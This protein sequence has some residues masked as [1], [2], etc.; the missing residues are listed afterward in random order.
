M[1]KRIAFILLSSILALS[2]SLSAC[3]PK[4]HAHDLQ[5]HAAKAATCFEDGSKEYFECPDCGKLFKDAEGKTELSRD[6]LKIDAT[7]HR[8][9]DEWSFDSEAHWHAA[10]CGHNEEIKDRQLHNFVDDRCTV[11][12]ELNA[13]GGSVT[14]SAVGDF[15]ILNEEER[16]SERLKAIIESANTFAAKLSEALLKDCELTENVTVSPISVYMALA[17]TAEASGGETR[18][19]I[20]SVLGVT[21]EQLH[22][23]FELLYRAL[24][25]TSND[26][27]GKLL[28][29]LDLS[30][31]I[32]V[33]KAL[34]VNQS[35]LKTLA[36]KY[37]CGAH[38]A[39]FYNKN[40]LANRAIQEFV[41][42]K[43]RGL[44]D[45]NFNLSTDTVFAIINTLYLKDVWNGFGE[46]LSLTEKPYSFNEKEIQLLKGNYREGRAYEADTFTHFYTQTYSG[47]KLKFL[48][49]KEGYS[50][51]EIFT[52][53]NIAKVNA[54]NFFDY[55]SIDG[56]NKQ[57]FFTRCLFPEFEASYRGE[58]VPALKETFGNMDLFS[59]ISCDFS[60]LTSTPSY[61]SAIIHMTKLKVD[62]KGIE[63]AAVTIVV[64]V[65]TSVPPEEFKKVYLDYVLDRSFAFVLTD[66]YDT[67]LFTGIVDKV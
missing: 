62:R 39:D 27:D 49:P 67:I 65:A 52:R 23:D 36:E 19:Q 29:V 58:I 61:C 45:Q 48:L 30:N 38:K 12:G 47:Y 66:R 44:I 37:F 17:V 40:D 16:Q 3:T 13:A 10:A 63:G 54:L 11:C 64:D 24:N 8:F 7:G 34:D 18:E 20:L 35:T 59:P 46:G 14:L 28:S 42:E 55:D 56:V 15:D 50:A 33:D 21:Y 26:D 2:V 60:S 1:K 32:W 41:K 5:Y 31:S 51:K 22:S 57:R 6:S 25:V 43:T 4:E 9:D 53:E